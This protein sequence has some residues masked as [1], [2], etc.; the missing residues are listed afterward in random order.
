[1]ILDLVKLDKESKAL[2]DQ[3]LTNEAFYHKKRIG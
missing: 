3:F 2:F 1:M